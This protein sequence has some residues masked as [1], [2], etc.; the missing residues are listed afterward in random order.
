[1]S[2]QKR[3]LSIIFFISLSLALA[4]FLWVFIEGTVLNSSDPNI[5]A[6]ALMLLGAGATVLSA[7]V[8]GISALLKTRQ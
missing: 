1:M 4:G 2:Q 3:V 7:L 8:W 5:G 6:G